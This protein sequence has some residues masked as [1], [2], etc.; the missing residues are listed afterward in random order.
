MEWM[1]ERKGKKLEWRNGKACNGNVLKQNWH[2]QAYNEKNKQKTSKW[3][4]CKYMNQLRTKRGHFFNTPKK[5]TFRILARKT[6][7]FLRALQ[8]LF[9]TICK[10]YQGCQ[11]VYFRTKN[12]ILGKFRRALATEYVGILYSHLCSLL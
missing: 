2:R 1:K 5:I 9:N 11:K 10:F 6:W 8:V 7:N 12:T 3:Q 4:K